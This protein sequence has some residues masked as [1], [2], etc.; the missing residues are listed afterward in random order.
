MMSETHMEKYK[1]RLMALIF[2]C[3]LLPL[4]F[5]IPTLGF[6]AGEQISIGSYKVQIGLTVNVAISVTN[7]EGVAGGSVKVVFDKSIVEVQKVSAGDFG[8]PVANIRNEEG[9]VYIAVAQPKAVGKNEATLAIIEF[10]GVMEGK[11]VLRIENAQ[12]NDEKGNLLTPT[13]TNGLIEVYKK[14]EAVTI[15]QVGSAEGKQGD[16]LKVL[17][18]ISNAVKIAGFQFTL[19]F[20]PSVVEIVDAYKGNLIKDFIFVRNINNQEGWVKVAASSAT[21]VSGSGDIVVVE[22]KLMG[23][24]GS[25]TSLKIKDLKLNDEAGKLIEAA[26]QDGLIKITGIPS[27]VVVKAS[28][29][30][31]FIGGN[32]TSEITLSIAPTGLSGYEIEVTFI[33]QLSIPP[34]TVPGPFEEALKKLKPTPGEDVIDIIKVELPE[35]AGLSDSSIKDDKV[36]LRAVDIQDKVQAGH[37]DI[38]LVKILVKGKAGGVVRVEVNVLRMDDDKGVGI[39]PTTPPAFIIVVPIIRPPPIAPDLPSPMDLD[40]DGLFEDINGNGRLDFD[41]VVKFFK[42]F[43]ESVVSEYAKFYDFNGNGRLDFDDIVKLFKKL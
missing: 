38:L 28:N 7:A 41:D 12:L 26:S 2:I 4:I 33:P 20:D 22:V 31:M 34:I 9:F 43:G 16:I 25:S 42:H 40:N 39:S 32:G 18:T 17:I 23:K 24:P 21:G 15:V 30:F 13:V 27:E 10:K 19:T 35:W 37:K 8:A 5:T 6:P 1:H 3:L 36:W 29:V 14:E 11:T